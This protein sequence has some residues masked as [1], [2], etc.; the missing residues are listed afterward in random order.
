MES[1][2]KIRIVVMGRIPDELNLR[3][4]LKWKSKLFAVSSS[5]QHHSMNN[6]QP[7]ISSFYYSDVLL[8]TNFPNASQVEKIAGD[9]NKTDLTIYLVDIP[10]EGNYFSRVFDKNQ[11]VITFYQ[12][13]NM[14]R[15]EHIPFENYVLK[16]LYMYSLLFLSSRNNHIVFK[17]EDLCLHYERN[18]CL[19]D[20]CYIKEEFVDSCIKPIICGECYQLLRKSHIQDELLKT[21]DDELKKVTR[22]FRYGIIHWLHT[23]PLAYLLVSAAVS[24]IIGAIISFSFK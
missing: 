9:D 14:L 13:K 19:F 7:D 6:M 18:G 2:V 20:G 16:R 15:E 3:K 24:A 4:L 23:H 12:A 22:G 8:R 17:D 1:V 11:I 5:K 21:V 10:I